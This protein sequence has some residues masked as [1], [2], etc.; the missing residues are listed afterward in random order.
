M[1]MQLTEYKEMARST[2]ASGDYDAMMRQER[3][4]EVGAKVVAG[5]G[6]GHG[7]LVLDIACGT[8]NAAIPAAATGATV[9]G[10]DLTPQMLE[11]AR[12]RADAA[13]VEVEWRLGDAE[14]LPFDD[15]SFDVV[16]STFGCQFAPRHEIVAEEIARVLR[17]G[18]RMAIAAWTPEGSIGD[19]FRTTGAYLPP[20]PEFVDPPLLWGDEQHVREIF[21]GT[22]IEVALER[23]EWNIHH[24]SID[25]AVEC[26]TSTLGPTVLARSLAETDGRWPE[27]HHDLSRLFERHNQSGNS[28]LTFAAEYLL[29]TGR[30][31][32]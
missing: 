9:T 29:I 16:L 11:V 14:E 17:P 24:D 1:V 13:G 27:L 21:E 4:Y 2:W 10:L 6:I 26:Y 19:F 8:G 18:G 25:A 3:L 20:F 32:A 23:E 5:A 28:M 22:G 15:R 30:K 7:D 12:G 31:S